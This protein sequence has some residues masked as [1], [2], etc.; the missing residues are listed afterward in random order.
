MPYSLEQME[1]TA[2][3]RQGRPSNPCFNSY[4]TRDLIALS[5]WASALSSPRGTTSHFLDA[6]ALQEA[7]P[8]YILLCLGLFRRDL[9]GDPLTV[10]APNTISGI[11][12]VVC[13][14]ITQVLKE[15]MRVPKTR[16]EWL[17]VSEEFFMQ[18]NFPN[19]I[20]ALDGKHIE[21]PPPRNSES[22]Y[23]Y[24]KHFNSIVLLAL[25]NAHLK[26]LFVDVG[27]ND[28]ISD[29]GV[30]NKCTL[31]KFIKGLKLNIAAGK[32][33]PS[34]NVPAPFVIMAEDAFPFE[35]NILNPYKGTSLTEEIIFNYR[36]SRARRVT[37]N[38][39]GILANR[40]QGFPKR[41]F[42]SP[43]K[44]NKYSHGCM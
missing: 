33:L 7:S 26:F 25:V 18:W 42:D 2:L 31:K 24:Y 30:Y 3:P 4:E 21:I 37:E 19:C 36:L 41:N 29:G 11:I 15:K 39:F 1:G 23:W 17:Q 32:F 9:T 6:G 14:A 10:L 38:A 28:R 43:C 44:G 27:T 34:T 12:P 35:E 22:T 20:G 5:S 8:D 13:K 16:E 40:F